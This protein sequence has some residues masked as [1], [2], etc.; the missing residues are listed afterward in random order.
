MPTDVKLN[1]LRDLLDTF[2][3][4]LSREA[5][6]DRTQDVTLHYADGSELLAEVIERT[7]P[8]QFDS[9]G[10]LESEVFTFLPTEAVGEPGQAEGEG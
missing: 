10:D 3:Y 6:I 9:P 7:S 2:D 1:E 8:E 5:A 4:P